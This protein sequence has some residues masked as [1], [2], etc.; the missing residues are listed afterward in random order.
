MLLDSGNNEGSLISITEYLEVKNRVFKSRSIKAEDLLLKEIK[1]SDR[2][3]DIGRLAE[4][5]DICNHFPMIIQ[6]IKN[7]S[8]DIYR[9]LSSN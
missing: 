7:Q 9:V 6:K 1:V 4:V 2:M 8:N 5:I 3:I